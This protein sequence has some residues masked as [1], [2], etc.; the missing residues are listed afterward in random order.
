M[1]YSLP[2]ESSIDF[3]NGS[4]Y[5]YNFIIKEFEKQFTCLRENIEK[6]LKLLVP[7]KK[8][9]KPYPTD[10]NILI[11]QDLWHAGIRKIK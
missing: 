2:K 11:A 8:L 4:N 7:K 3:Y 1:K 5:N 6:Y 10:Y 9:Q